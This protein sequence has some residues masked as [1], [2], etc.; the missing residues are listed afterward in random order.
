MS[1]LGLVPTVP[2][3]DKDLL[4]FGQGNLKT[5]DD[6]LPFRN[7]LRSSFLDRANL[8]ASIAGIGLGWYC[9]KTPSFRLEVQS[10]AGSSLWRYVQIWASLVW[11]VAKRSKQQL[12]FEKSIVTIS[13]Y[14][15]WQCGS[16]QRLHNSWSVS[17]DAAQQQRD[18]FTRP[19]RHWTSQRVWGI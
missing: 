7:I 12:F 5:W 6:L 10:A 15:G 19:T 9:G 18:L 3:R 2:K 1:L 8:R 4:I 16:N 13:R 17:A 14:T 11:I